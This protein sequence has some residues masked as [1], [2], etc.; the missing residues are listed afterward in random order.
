MDA[1]FTCILWYYNTINYVLAIPT[2]AGGATSA[3]GPEEP[4]VT[5]S[6]GCHGNPPVTETTG[7]TIASIC[8]AIFSFTCSS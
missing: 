5:S 2:G 1:L 8:S 4:S 6:S 7:L 3:A